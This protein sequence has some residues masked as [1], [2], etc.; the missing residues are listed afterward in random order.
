MDTAPKQN[1]DSY[2]AA[3]DTHIPV[4]DP[5][6][7]VEEVRHHGSTGSVIAVLLIVFLLIVGA[8]YV[9]GQRLE[10]QRA[11]Q[12]IPAVGL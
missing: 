12:V 6:P 1:S 4:L 2:A 10:E 5:A 8:F 11:R 9:W 3:L 7:V